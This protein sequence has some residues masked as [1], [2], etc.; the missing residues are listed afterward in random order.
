MN[1]IVFFFFSPHKVKPLLTCLQGL[2]MKEGK[3]VVSACRPSPELRSCVWLS[4]SLHGAPLVLLQSLRRH[5]GHGA[6]TSLRSVHIRSVLDAFLRH[7]MPA[8]GVS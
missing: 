4:P 7:H 2:I 5:W 8:A 6:S 3:H 1:S